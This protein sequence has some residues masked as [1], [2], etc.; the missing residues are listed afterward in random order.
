MGFLYNKLMSSGFRP[1]G[2]Y[3]FAAGGKAEEMVKGRRRTNATEE[4]VN[5]SRAEQTGTLHDNMSCFYVLV[6]FR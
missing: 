3:E 1:E 6:C 5:E 4:P 2:E